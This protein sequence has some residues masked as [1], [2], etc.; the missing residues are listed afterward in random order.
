MW[1]FYGKL[2]IYGNLEKCHI[3][4]L[5]PDQMTAFIVATAETQSASVMP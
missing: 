3:L 5:T 1:H 4:D 2:E